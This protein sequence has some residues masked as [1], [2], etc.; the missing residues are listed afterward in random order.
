MK[1][2]HDRIS[3]KMKSLLEMQGGYLNTFI[4]SD[5]KDM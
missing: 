3:E 2:E 1:E 4:A 5:D